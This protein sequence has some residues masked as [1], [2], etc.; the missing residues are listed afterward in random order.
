MFQKQASEKFVKA[1]EIFSKYYASWLKDINIEEALNSEHPW[2]QFREDHPQTLQ[3][4]GVL[5]KMPKKFYKG[6][7]KYTPYIP[8]I[9]N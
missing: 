2:Q 7:R 1:Y 5:I 9:I 3:R 6:N 4:D 8:K